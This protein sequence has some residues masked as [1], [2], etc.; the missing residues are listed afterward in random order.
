MNTYKVFFKGKT[1]MLVKAK[2][3]LDAAMVASQAF[4]IN[5]TLFCYAIKLDVLKDLKTDVWTKVA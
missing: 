5:L 3:E 1:P 2:D 4:K